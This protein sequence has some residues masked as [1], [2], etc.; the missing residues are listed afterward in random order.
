MLRRLTGSFLNKR[1]ILKYEVFYACQ[2]MQL[3]LLESGKVLKPHSPA[4]QIRQIF[5]AAYAGV[6]VAV[7][8]VAPHAFRCKVKLQRNLHVEMVFF[9]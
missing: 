6:D 4:H 3:L 9:V 2:T 8:W 7:D 5:Y 1:K